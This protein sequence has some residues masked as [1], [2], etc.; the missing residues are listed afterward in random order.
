MMF[1]ASKVLAFAIEPLCWV[2][3]LLAAGLLLWPHRPRLGRTLAWTSLAALLLSGWVFIPTQLLRNL[4]SRYPRLPANTDMRQYVGVIVLGGALGDPQLWVEHQQVALNDQAER[5]T[6]AVGLMQKY[7]DLK[8]V[9]SGG[10]ASV[11]GTGVTESQLARAFF[12]DM[13]VPPAR[14]MYESSSRNTYEN[15][16][17]SAMMPGVDKRQRW[18]LL[19]SSFHMPRSMGVFEKLGWNITPY[20]VDYRTS[21]EGSWHDF[22]LH[23]GPG[24]WVLALHETIGYYVYKAANMI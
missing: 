14:V 12:D 6:A 5:M 23:F 20:P 18:L 11:A 19:T 3:L 7:P 8:V 4:E 13:G 24:Q 2:L 22:S 17:F 1:V 9:F 10:I 21:S 15:G 16:Y